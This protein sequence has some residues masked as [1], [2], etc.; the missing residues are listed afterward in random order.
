MNIFTPKRNKS[1]Y[2]YKYYFAW[3]WNLTCVYSHKLRAIFY[4]NETQHS[5][6]LYLDVLLWSFHLCTEILEKSK[7]I[8]QCNACKLK[9][10][11]YCLFYSKDLIFLR[12]ATYEWNEIRLFRA[13][14]EIAASV[15]A[16]QAQHKFL[17]LRIHQRFY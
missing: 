4:W 1:N 15:Y 3:C 6:S 11:Y 9:C 8:R 5:S 17:L 10:E 16:Q 2:Y 14:E 7:E 12:S 13:W